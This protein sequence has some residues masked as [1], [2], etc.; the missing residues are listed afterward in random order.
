METIFHSAKQ[1]QAAPEPEPQTTPDAVPASAQQADA[2]DAYTGKDL[3]MYRVLLAVE[4][5]ELSPAE[6]A[7]K[8]DDLDEPDLQ[9]GPGAAAG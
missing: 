4:R 5:G 9:V 8:L 3:E 2:P 1:P 7:R 6:A